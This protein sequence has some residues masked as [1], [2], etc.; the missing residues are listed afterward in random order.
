MTNLQEGNNRLGGATDDKAKVADN[1]DAL[2]AD[3]LTDGAHVQLAADAVALK[4]DGVHG[5]SNIRPVGADPGL[6][7]CRVIK[8]EN[9]QS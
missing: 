7:A 8:L 5:L 9:I 6:A 2:L 1:A 3:P 4:E